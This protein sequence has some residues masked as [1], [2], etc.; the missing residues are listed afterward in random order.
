[1]GWPLGLASEHPGLGL[2]PI[3]T[4]PDHAP[5]VG[6]DED[7]A[8]ADAHIAVQQE[9]VKLPVRQVDASGPRRRVGASFVAKSSRICHRPSLGRGVL[10]AM[11]S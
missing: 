10:G 8:E 2:C 1:M 7:R 4:V 9:N 5:G 3:W 11:T 6:S